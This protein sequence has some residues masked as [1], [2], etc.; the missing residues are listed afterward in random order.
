[1]SYASAVKTA[2][3]AASGTFSDAVYLAGNTLLAIEM[4]SAWTTASISI[5]ASSDGNTYRDVVNINGVAITISASADKY[6]VLDSDNTLGINYLKLKSS[7]TQEAAR[8]L[9]L[10]SR[11]IVQ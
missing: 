10:I 9:T 5:L 4:P 3:I 2:S 1:V 11:G 6:I 7:A 8:T